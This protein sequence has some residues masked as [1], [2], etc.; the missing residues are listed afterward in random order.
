[1]YGRFQVRKTTIGKAA[2]L[3]E[4]ALVRAGGLNVSFSPFCPD[5]CLSG[6]DNL[7]DI[8]RV[9]HLA[10]MQSSSQEPVAADV[11][12]RPAKERWRWLHRLGYVTT[13]IVF[14][15]IVGVGVASFLH[16]Q[17]DRE[18]TAELVEESRTQEGP[19]Q[20]GD[21]QWVRG[22]AVRELALLP[23]L[24]ALQGN[25]LRFVVM[26]S[27]SEWYSLALS[28]EPRAERTAGVL[29]VSKYSDGEPGQ[30]STRRF[31]VPRAEFLK[32]MS[33][34][35]RLTDHWEGDANLCLDGA[36]MAFE[37]VRAARITSGVGNCSPHYDRLRAMM[38]QTVRRFAP[39]DDL[40]IDL[41]WHR[42]EF[43]EGAAAR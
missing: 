24:H 6:H 41:N 40:P 19:V 25:G 3:A 39:D 13:L 7:A 33:E 5:S 36:P 17:R 34:F 30:R 4:L 1:M 23:P 15:Q 11:A 26:P 38:L 12:S 29:I 28:I 8:R 27:F 9:R 20:E 16:W 21:G 2:L 43:E 22:S 42:R 31:T 10:S 32:A 35:D 37:R 14:L 18:R